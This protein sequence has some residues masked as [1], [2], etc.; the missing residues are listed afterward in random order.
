M[1]TNIEK[2]DK[3]LN[4]S[5]ER[6]EIGVITA[7]S[8]VGKTSLLTLIANNIWQDG[9]NVLQ[10]SAD[11]NETMILKK[12]QAIISGIPQSDL[13]DNIETV[14]S[15]LEEAYKH[16]KNKLIIKN[17]REEIEVN[18]VIDL[19]KEIQIKHETKFDTIILDLSSLIKVS[20]LQ[21]ISDLAADLNV[22]I[23]IGFQEAERCDGKQFSDY[24]NSFDNVKFVVSIKKDSNKTRFVDVSKSKVY[25]NT[26]MFNNCDFDFN[27]MIFEIK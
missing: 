6:G 15:K 4:N 5:I 13:E 11:D 17:I 10:L 14:K 25:R 1:K 7:K 3:L 20:Q 21:Y 22:V 27:R 9:H 19:I 16:N 23:F 2:F 24:F 8:G 26:I 12:H 18:S